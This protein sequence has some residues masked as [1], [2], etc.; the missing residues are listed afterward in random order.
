MAPYLPFKKM[1]FA[2][3][4][5]CFLDPSFEPPVQNHHT[6]VKSAVAI[7]YMW[8][9]CKICTAGR[10]CPPV[11][12]T[13]ALPRYVWSRLYTHPDSWCWSAWTMVLNLS[14]GCSSLGW[15]FPTVR[16]HRGWW[17]CRVW[18]VQPSPACHIKWGPRV[19]VAHEQVSVLFL[20]DFVVEWWCLITRSWCIKGELKAKISRRY[21]VEE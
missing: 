12:G 6:V 1:L 16:K 15:T 11:A 2:L 3:D 14:I 10:A 4:V 18:Q 9:Y 5:Y 8:G 20:F 19:L 7:V 21:V 13:H 17:S